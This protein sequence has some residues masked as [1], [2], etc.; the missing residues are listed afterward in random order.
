VPL[1][2]VNGGELLSKFIGEGEQR[3][4]HVIDAATVAQPS[5]IFFDDI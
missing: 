2:V 1:W 3:V 4:R 5:I